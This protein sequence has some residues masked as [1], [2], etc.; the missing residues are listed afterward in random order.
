MHAEVCPHT[1]KW[2]WITPTQ[3]EPCSKDASYHCDMCLIVQSEL[4][5]L[6]IC[7]VIHRIFFIHIILIYAV[8]YKNVN[9]CIFNV[10]YLDKLNSPFFFLLLLLPSGQTKTF[11]WELCKPCLVSW[12]FSE[13]VKW[14][15]W[16]LKITALLLVP[17]QATANGD[18]VE[19]N[20]WHECNKFWLSTFKWNHSEGILHGQ[21][22]GVTWEEGRK[23]RR[24]VNLNELQYVTLHS[25]MCC[26]FSPFLCLWSHIPFRAEIAGTLSACRWENNLHLIRVLSFLIWAI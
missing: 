7:I 17:A 1:Y 16:M 8:E 11:S 22:V 2:I 14:R 5:F 13:M 20:P 19:N 3:K 10:I 21:G 12:A 24:Q 6:V 25:Q 4:S 23:R 18:G 26:P 9:Y 15:V